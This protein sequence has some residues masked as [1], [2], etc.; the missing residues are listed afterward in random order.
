MSHWINRGG[1][2]RDLR[3]A[4]RTLP[5]GRNDKGPNHSSP[6]LLKLAIRPPVAASKTSNL[7]DLTPRA[8]KN[9]PSP[10]LTICA[11]QIL[12]LSGVI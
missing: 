8:A 4:V 2:N 3:I 5:S 9:R 12:P 10:D 11:D 1:A 7:P 6:R